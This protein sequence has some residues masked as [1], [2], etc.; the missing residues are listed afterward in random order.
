MRYN[1]AMAANIL[2]M[3]KVLLNIIRNERSLTNSMTRTT[4]AMYVP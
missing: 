3:I 2:S 4:K 1:R